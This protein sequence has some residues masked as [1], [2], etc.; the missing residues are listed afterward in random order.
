[1]KRIMIITVVASCLLSAVYSWAATTAPNIWFKH[2]MHQIFENYNNTRISFSLRQFDVTNVFLKQLQ[3]SIDAAKKHMPNE[4]RDGTKLD[5]ELF[6][7]RLDQLRES[8]SSF[9]FIN[10]VNFRDPLLTESLSRDMFNMCVTCHKEVKMEHLF[11]MPKRRTLYEEYMHKVADN[12]DL[13]LI[14]SEDDSLSD[15]TREHIQLV[16]YY[17]D[18]LTTVFPESGPS[19]VITDKEHLQRQIM[20]IKKG[21]KS[22]GKPIKT[23]DLEKSRTTLN[24]L[25]VTC[26]ESEWVK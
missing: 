7:K 13:A 9:K 3:E 2:H 18:R 16:N 6:T 4:N 26:H 25:C 11:K 20:E 8:V 10:E 22:E 1:M 14:K 19:G 5:E 12:F 17:I 21:L 24:G 23:A 15:E